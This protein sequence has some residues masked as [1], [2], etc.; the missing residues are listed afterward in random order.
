VA[1]DTTKVWVDAGPGTLANLQLHASLEDLTG[2]VV[3]HVH[4]DHWLELPVLY[5]A[6][7]WFRPRPVLPVYTTREVAAALR[8]FHPD[9]LDVVFDLSVVDHTSRITIGD[10]DVR[11]SQTDHPVETLAMRFDHG[12]SSLVYSSDT[13]P[14]WSLGQLGTH[15]DVALCEATMLH[16]ERPDDLPHLSALQAG[17][18]AKECGVGRLIVTHYSPDGDPA[19]YETEAQAAFGRPVH[20]AAPHERYDV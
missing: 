8:G 14:G 1:S 11:F 16:A 5:N 12:D 15:I 18:D 7:K 4:P 13:G 9:D 2:I 17:L 19:D 20:I 3:S 6:L 10:I